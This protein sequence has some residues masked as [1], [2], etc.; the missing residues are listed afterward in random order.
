MLKTWA[1][2][3]GTL[4]GTIDTRSYGIE[5]TEYDWSKVNNVIYEENGVVIRSVP[6][7]HFEQ[8][9][10][11]ILEWNGL[12]LA[13]SGV[14]FSHSLRTFETLVS[15]QNAQSA[16]PSALVKCARSRF[17]PAYLSMT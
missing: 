11:L 5:V 14:D 12:K 9:A 4:K 6:A 8:S 10:S 17:R 16:T 7:I 2:M 1:W 13:Y 15:E 3:L